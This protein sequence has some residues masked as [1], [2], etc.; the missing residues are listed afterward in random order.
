[1][2]VVEDDALVRSVTAETPR[3]Q[4]HEVLE[5][6]EAPSAL[7]VR[8]KTAIDILS[9]EI[10]LSEV[11]RLALAREARGQLCGYAANT[12]APSAATCAN[13]GPTA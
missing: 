4:G 3:A 6:P 5:A 9:M 12:P 1:V 10:G 7:G 13:R 11:S 2:P 8:E